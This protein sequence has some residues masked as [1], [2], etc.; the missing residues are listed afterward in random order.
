MLELNGQPLTLAQVAAVASGDEQVA[1]AARARMRVEA[2]RAVVERIVAEE[3]VV[4]GVNTGFGKLSD[5]TIPP[6]E[7]RELQLNLVRSHACGVGAPLPVAEVRAMMLLRANVLALGYSGARA[8]VIEALLAL[9]ARDV[10]PVV[11]EKG[12]VGAS[13]DLAPLAHLAQVVIGEGEAFY[14]GAR[15]PGGEA[16]RRAGLLPLQLEA[17]E[18]LALLNGTQAMTAVGALAI[19]RAE[20]VARVADV[21]GAMT[22]EALRG[23]PVAFD[24]RIHN[25][26]PH[27]GQTEAAAHLRALLADSEIRRSHIENDPRVQDAYSLRCMPQVHGAV[28][29]ALG[30]ARAVV[31]IET[32][33]ATDNPLVFTDTN[34]VL[35]GGNF[36]GAPVALVCDYAVIA[37]VDL[38]SI[39]ERRVDRLVNP[40]TNEDLPPFLTTH[41][42]LASGFMLAQIVAAALV[43]EARALAHPASVDNVP[44]DGGKEDH[45]SMGMTA[46]TKLRRV[47]ESAEQILAIEL[48]TAAEALEHR[49]PLQPGVG[50]RRAYQAV[51]RHAPRLTRDR[52]LTPDFEKLTEAIRRGEFD[53]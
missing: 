19:A 16:L 20:R 14:Q 32:G 26:R 24:E 33:S 51:R 52:T 6:D 11:P 15:L 53:V 43:A 44:T 45:V 48:L 13:G 40:D 8:V 50:V 10:I 37:L 18:G 4:Y 35:S 28:R 38:M 25:A 1:L 47:V 39:T 41:P 46:A 23:T 9:L 3:R 42:G 12:S 31:E 49:A 21:A 7:L 2:G 22:L 30:H 36:H 34:E 5:Y 29:D 17:K 27:A